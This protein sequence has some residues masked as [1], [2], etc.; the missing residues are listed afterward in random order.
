[1]RI[2][3]VTTLKHLGGFRVR[4]RFSDGVEGEA[5]LR[6]HFAGQKGLLGELASGPAFAN[7]HLNK[8]AGVLAWRNGVEFDPLLLWSKVSGREPVPVAVAAK[9]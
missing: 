6:H 3:R 9:P 1:M 2:Q 8:E 5:D 7:V 4:V